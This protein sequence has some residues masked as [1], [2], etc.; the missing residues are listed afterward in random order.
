MSAITV[1]GDLVH[2]EVL[3]RGGRPVI[4]LHGWIGS[5]RYWIPTMRQL[6]LKFRVYAVDLFGFGDSAKNPEKYSIDHQVHMLREFM[7]QLGVPKAAFLAHGLGT[8]V[9]IHFANKFP[10]RVARMLLISAPLF[11]PGDMNSRIPPGQQRKLT[12]ENAESQSTSD[13]DAT[14]HALPDVVSE[15]KTIPSRPAGL[16]EVLAERSKRDVAPTVP[17]ASRETI[18]NANM[19]DR[20]KLRQ[21]A[22]DRA[23]AQDSA[24]RSMSSAIASPLNSAS[25]LTNGNQLRDALGNDME[26]LLGRTFKRTEPEYEKLKVDVVKADSKVLVVSSD[27]FNAGHLLDTLRLLP[28]P[29]IIV[30]GESD[31][32]IQ[33][34][35][36]T[37]WGYITDGKDD[38]TLPVQ[39]AGVRHFPMLE[40]ETFHRLVGLFLETQ[41]ISKIELKERW[42]RRSR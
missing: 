6:Q 25:P 17:S 14:S 4:L 28:M 29:L 35:D 23:G 21:A 11:D 32:I 18:Q 5:W 2:Y 39:F 20:E 9:A 24:N 31:P 40:H 22:M 12:G 7:D 36:E 37:I 41:D 1:D 33:A 10:D 27:Q 16:D 3:G 8:Q 19:I 13:S 42:R 34:P 15:Q 30:H 26:A 38:S